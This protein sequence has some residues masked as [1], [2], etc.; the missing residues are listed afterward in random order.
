M[1][2]SPEA[3]MQAQIDNLK[4]STA[5]SLEQWVK[6]AQGSIRLLQLDG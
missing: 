2:K 5:K 4:K 6:I 3:A 1:P